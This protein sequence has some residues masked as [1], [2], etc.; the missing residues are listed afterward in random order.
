MPCGLLLLDKPRG[1]RSS[2]CVAILRRRLG[3][4]VKV[5]H[6]GTLDSTARGLLVLLAGGAT[7]ASALV[8]DLPKTY[9][10]MFRLGEERSTGDS[11][12]KIVFSGPVPSCPTNLIENFLP[13]FYGTRLQTPPSIS[14]IRIDG[15][16]AHHL[17][18]KGR[19]VSLA[20]RPIH[21]TS[22]NILPLP[23]GGDLIGLRI[24]CG[25]G[26]YV[27]SIVTDLGRLLG[28]GAHVI[29]LVRQSS[30]NLNLN[31]A[32]PFSEL[33]DD[34][35][36]LEDKIIPLS[37]LAENFYSY[38]TDQ[39]TSMDI[40]NG[41]EIP[42]S[43]LTFHSEGIISPDKGAVVLGEDLF[44]FG[45]VLPEGLYKGKSNIFPLSDRIAP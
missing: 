30:G 24:R 20:P 27:R 2:V 41:K 14:A 13:S 40:R 43:E 35:L 38:T 4:T 44:S 11:T 9:D 6:G 25:K 29:S 15:E 16:R 33:E 8:M 19:E 21:I 17:A 22:I 28:C 42:L 23:S 34:S 7:R 1:I 31:E 5:G 10:V 39:E 37:R 12:G 18:R 26:T 36:P 32:V 45:A 3:K